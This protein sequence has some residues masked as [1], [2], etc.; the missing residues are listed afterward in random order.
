[1]GRRV[2]WFLCV[3]L[4]VGEPRWVGDWSGA[5]GRQQCS[6]SR[7]SARVAMR[8]RV[9]GGLNSMRLAGYPCTLPAGLESAE[10]PG[11]GKAPA[12]G[13]MG[14]LGGIAGTGMAGAGM[15]G[16]SGAGAAAAFDDDR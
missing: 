11:A 6:G 13:G 7:V 5:E 2:S 15:G 1:M 14:G 8:A 12:F 9:P 3:L 4:L 16:L 10:G